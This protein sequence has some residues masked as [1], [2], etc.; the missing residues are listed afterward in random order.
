[1]KCVFLVQYI[2]SNLATE[3]EENPNQLLHVIIP[4]Q[5]KL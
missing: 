4:K 5:N 2:T 3:F 1:M